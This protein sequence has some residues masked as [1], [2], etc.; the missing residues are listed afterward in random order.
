MA[1]TKE[2]DFM[3]FSMKIF[4]LKVLLGF[5]YDNCIGSWEGSYILCTH[6]IGFTDYL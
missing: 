2:R 6:R 4:V 1:K 3:E 5:L